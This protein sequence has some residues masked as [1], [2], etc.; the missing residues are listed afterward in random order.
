MDTYP[1]RH[2]RTI[3]PLG[4][5]LHRPEVVAQITGIPAET[6]ISLARR[7]AAT[8]GVAPVM[9]SGLEYSDSGVQAIRATQVLWALAGQL[10]VPGGSARG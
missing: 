8:R 1:P 4:L 3:E 5:L 6:V 2:S 9:Y 7:I 10:D